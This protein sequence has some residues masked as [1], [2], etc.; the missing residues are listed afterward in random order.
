[1]AEVTRLACADTPEIE[2]ERDRYIDKH[3]HVELYFPSSLFLFDFDTGLGVL[4]GALAIG[5]Q[6]DP[7]GTDEAASRLDAA[8][9]PAKPAKKR[10]GSLPARVKG[11]L[12]LPQ[13]PENV[14]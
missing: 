3:F 7:L 2:R 6:A 14:G 10:S 1:M 8:R 11:W 9:A 13:V 12:G 4:E 5:R